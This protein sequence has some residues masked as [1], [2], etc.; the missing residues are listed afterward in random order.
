MANL[1]DKSLF[2]TETAEENRNKIRIDPNNPAFIRQDQDEEADEF[3]E[4]IGLSNKGIK[5]KI[6]RTDVDPSILELCADFSQGYDSDSSQEGDSKKKRKKKLQ[7]D[8]DMF[9]YAARDDD[10]QEDK[11]QPDDEDVYGKLKRKQVKFVDYTEIEWQEFSEE[12]KDIEDEEESIPSTPNDSDDEIIDEEV[13]LAGSKKHAP[14]IEKFNLRQEAAEGAFTEDGGYIRKAA[15][16]RAHQ[17][18]WLAGLTKGA[19]K[20]TA[21]AAQRRQEREKALE[22]REKAEAALSKTELLERLIRLLPPRETPLEALARLNQRKK[23]N[24]QPSQKWK[25]SKMVVDTEEGTSEEDAAKVKEHIEEI[26]TYADRLLNLGSRQIYSLKRE[27]MIMLWQDETQSRFREDPSAGAVTSGAEK[28]E[29]KW[30]GTED[31][32]TGFSLEDMKGWKEAG[33][34]GNG[35]LVRPAGSKD[36]WQNSADVTF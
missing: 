14:K 4:D 15:D 9:A 20:R 1:A 23:K 7:N 34:F 10:D 8:D 13:G 33:F 29:Y 16:P 35:V 28:W 30:P 17:D 18:V 2:T 27:R 19:I 3:E 21:D 31:V 36:D 11:Q 25:K 6:V 22:K 5:R 26:T 12:E 32:H 24:W